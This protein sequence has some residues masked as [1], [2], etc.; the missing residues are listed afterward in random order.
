M[1]IADARAI[2]N[3]WCARV[4]RPFNGAPYCEPEDWGKYEKNEQHVEACQ[5]KRLLDWSRHAAD[6][7]TAGYK[8]FR[9]RYISAQI[10]RD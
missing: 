6:G 4:A 10:L 8:G 2:Q 9:C 3:C 5:V 7:E 1:K